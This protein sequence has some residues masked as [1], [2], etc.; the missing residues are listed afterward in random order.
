MFYW[1]IVK[2]STLIG[3]YQGVKITKISH[4]ILIKYIVEAFYFFYFFGSGSIEKLEKLDK[5]SSLGSKARSKAWCNPT[6]GYKIGSKRINA[7]FFQMLA[8]LGRTLSSK[9]KKYPPRLT[10]LNPGSSAG[11]NSAGQASFFPNQ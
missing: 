8:W 3:D 2:Q 6:L 9:L 11:W 5:T 7:W 4:I 10:H 1:S